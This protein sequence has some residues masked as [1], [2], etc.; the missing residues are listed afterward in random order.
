MSPGDPAR[1]RNPRPSGKIYETPDR[2]SFSAPPRATV[3]SR[4]GRSPGPGDAVGP[5]EERDSGRDDGDGILVPVREA[6]RRPG[7]PRAD[8][9]LTKHRRGSLSSAV[10]GGLPSLSAVTT[11]M[12]SVDSVRRGCRHGVPM[13]AF[14]GCRSRG[15]GRDVE[16]WI[17]SRRVRPSRDPTTPTSSGAPRAAALDRRAHR[18]RRVGAAS[19]EQF[20]GHVRHDPHFSPLRCRLRFAD[21]AAFAFPSTGAA[22][23]RRMRTRS[24]PSSSP[25]ISMLFIRLLGLTG[26]RLMAT[27]R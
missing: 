3:D 16:R 14:A 19:R 8:E 6:G 15:R 9:L 5:L 7:S 17:E 24:G 26:Q 22:A 20:L 2:T 13:R 11:V 18:A 25:S 1:S 23:T 12:P 21:F 10:K 4:T 27:M